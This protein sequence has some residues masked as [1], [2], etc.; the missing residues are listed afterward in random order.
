M[1]TNWNQWLEKKTFPR[2]ARIYKSRTTLPNFPW[3]CRIPLNSGGTIFASTYLDVSI[4][5]TVAHCLDSRVSLQINTTD[6]FSPCTRPFLF[7]GA[8]ASQVKPTESCKTSLRLRTLWVP[9]RWGLRYGSWQHDF[10]SSANDQWADFLRVI[11][12][13]CHFSW[14]RIAGRL[15]G[16]SLVLQNKA[17]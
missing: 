14:R 10:Y 4:R 3:I 12:Y 6:I 15:L 8:L 11:S 17:V 13:I 5:S 1:G 2:D 16:S 7:F 9:Q